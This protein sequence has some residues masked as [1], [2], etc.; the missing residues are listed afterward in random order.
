MKATEYT[1]EVGRSRDEVVSVVHMGDEHVG[2]NIDEKLLLEVV[3]RI[4]GPHTYW[5]TTGDC[6]ES[7]T[8]DDRRFEVGNFPD[9]FTIKMVADPVKYEVEHYA[10]IFSPIADKCMAALFG[11]HEF[12]VIS[13]QDRDVYNDLWK[14]VGVPKERLLGPI[15]F[16]RLRFVSSGKVIWRP[17]IFMTHGNANGRK[18]GS[19][20][21]QLEGYP[22]AFGADVYACGHAHKK[23]AFKDTRVSMDPNTGRP[24]SET[25]AY[26]ATGSFLNSTSD[27]DHGQYNERKTLYPQAYGPVEMHFYPNRK[28]IKLV[29]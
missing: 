4:K 6:I 7:I 28:E 17:T 11:N 15:G 1:I 25:V 22:K 5:F 14:S 27:S 26:S 29:L 19:V 10:D 9:W 21:N 3:E 8:P 12:T 18:K 23:V 20:V 2:G 24:I 16:L 13:K